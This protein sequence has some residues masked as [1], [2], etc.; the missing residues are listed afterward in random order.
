MELPKAYDAIELDVERRLHHYLHCDPGEIRRVAIVGANTADEIERL[1]GRYPNATF[2]C[3]E[4]SPRYLPAL[5]QKWGHDQ[6]VRIHGV[7]ISDQKGKALFHELAMPGNGSLLKPDVELWST[8]TECKDKMTESY[9]VETCLLD[10]FFKTTSLDLLWVDVQG[11]EL[12]V[13]RGGG[14]TLKQARA[15]FLEI[16]LVRGPYEGGALFR[17]LDQC[18]L[19]HGFICCGQGIDPWNFTG[20]ALWV[21]NI[22]SMVCKE[23]PCRK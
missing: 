15:V 1:S 4:P 23:H 3:F 8:V 22:E 6:K 9:E 17:D 18:L 10:E 13:L 11:A 20:V 14:E 16:T 19:E 21:K 2:D 5:K 7:A 12:N